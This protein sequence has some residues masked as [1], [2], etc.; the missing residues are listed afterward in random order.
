MN[1]IRSIS[2][3]GTPVTNNG[4]SSQLNHTICDKCKKQLKRSLISHDLYTM[5]TVIYCPDHPLSVWEDV[6][7]KTDI[8]VTQDYENRDKRFDIW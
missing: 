7:N 1:K 2:L 3:D 4:S 8:N 6:F 5:Y